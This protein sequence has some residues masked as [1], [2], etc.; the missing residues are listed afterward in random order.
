MTHAIR[1]APCRLL[2]GALALALT[3]AAPAG[4]PTAAAPQTE[5][6]ALSYGC[7]LVALT[8]PSGTPPRTVA[9]ATAPA[10]ALAA[11]WKFDNGAKRFLGYS[12]LPNVPNDLVRL[13]RLDPAF[14]C[15]AAP[16]TLTRPLMVPVGP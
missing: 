13:S 9:L 5:P 2:G 4:V 8:W 3:F 1:R 7:N 10:P 16:A 6:V 11:I 15:V 14:V 12:P